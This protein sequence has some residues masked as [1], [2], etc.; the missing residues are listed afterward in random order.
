MR[1]GRGPPWRG[2]GV[3]RALLR[4]ALR[5]AAEAGVERVSLSVERA[6]PAGRLYAAEGFTTVESGTDSDTMVKRIALPR[7]I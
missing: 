6:N 4:D 1:G 3:G 7:R 2:K 5:R